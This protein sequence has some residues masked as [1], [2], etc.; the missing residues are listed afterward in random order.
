MGLAWLLAKGDDIVPIPGTKRVSRLEEKVAADGVTLSA[1]QMVKLDNTTP[2]A[3][4]HHN[5]AQMDMIG[6]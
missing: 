5:A 3:G 2:A 1:E 4:E 6:R